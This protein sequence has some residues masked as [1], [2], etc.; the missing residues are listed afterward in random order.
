MRMTDGAVERRTGDRR[1]ED[2]R[3]RD[4]RVLYR[5]AADRAP[6]PRAGDE[7]L[8]LKGSEGK[9]AG[10]ARRESETLV[11]H[12]SARLLTAQETERKRIATELHDELGHSLVMMKFRSGLIAN[13]LKEDQAAALEE[14]RTLSGLIDK[15]ID[16]VRRLSRDLRPLIL[17]ELGLSA[18]IRWLVETCGRSGPSVT[19]SVGEI[20]AL[21]PPDV[22][23]VV[24]RI[25]QQAM[26][27]ACQHSGAAH[28]SLD[29]ERRGP[30]LVF[31]V[32]DDGGGFDAAEVVAR[33][34]SERGLGLATMKERARMLGGSLSVWTERGRGT[35][36]TLEI[37]VRNGEA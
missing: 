1:V 17:D 8:D 27:N 32:D 26:T 10:G 13:E 4:R 15:T 35:R 18:A 23:V 14:C 11:N 9:E 21:L 3:I 12:L 34:T 5:R 28:I 24:Y 37:P 7:P 6:E 2:R 30:S 16:D 20:D 22:Q 36:I 19:A 29:V 33:D 25:L 31:V